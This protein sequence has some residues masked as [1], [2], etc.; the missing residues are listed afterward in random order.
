M[1]SSMTHTY[2]GID[3][4]KKINNNCKN[5]IKT[6]LEYYKLFSQGSDPLMFYHFLIGPKA[7]KCTDIQKTIHSNKTREFFLATIDYIYQNKLTSNSEIMA[8]LYGYIC[9]YMLDLHTHPIIYYKSGIFDKKNKNTYKYNGLHQAIE[10]GIDLYFINKRETINK[11]KFK[12]HKEIF[13]VKKLTKELKEIINYSIGDTYSLPNISNIYEKS[14]WYMTNFFKIANYDPYGIK[15]FLYKIADKILP[16]SIINFKELSFYNDYPNIHNWM[17][18]S[19]NK[20]YLPWDNTISYTTSFLD[21]YNIALNK[22]IKTI[23]EVTEMLDNNNLN[24]KRLKQIF[25]NLSYVTG[26]DC[27]INVDFKYFEK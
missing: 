14:I 4:Y 17:N 7:K 12:V 23:E 13:N 15:L 24:K 6:S 18:L 25:N 2:F 3:V 26:L 11:N 8:Y 20:W 22:A 5:K 9:H 21:L 19:K 10:Y 1:P 27:N 16:N